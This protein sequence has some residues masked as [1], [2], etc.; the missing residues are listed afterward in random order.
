ML[1]EKEAASFYV[2]GGG[3]GGG[4]GGGSSVSFSG[5]PTGQ[6]GVAVNYTKG[7]VTG[8]VGVSGSLSSSG[9]SVNG[10]Y[11]GGKITF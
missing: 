9:V 5:L 1:T 7:N 2:K 4:G 8:T 11:V 6:S 3:G 10:V